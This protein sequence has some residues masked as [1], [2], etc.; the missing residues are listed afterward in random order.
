MA[1]LTVTYEGGRRLAAEVRGHRIESDLTERGGGQDS[2]PQPFDIFVAAHGMCMTLF[3]QMFLERNGLS[4][5][6]LALDIEYEMARDPHRLGRVRG[7]LHVPNAE[8][9]KR[10]EAVIRAALSCPVHHSLS[11]DIEVTLELAE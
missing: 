1:N 6:G 2:A 8:L 3:A 9:G 7:V 11:E 5:E 10:A 4:T